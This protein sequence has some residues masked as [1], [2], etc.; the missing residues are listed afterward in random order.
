MNELTS[1]DDMERILGHGTRFLTY[2]DLARAESIEELFRKGFFVLLYEHSRNVGH[3]CCV[4]RFP[5]RIEVFDSYGIKPDDELK[6]TPR[7]FR[8]KNHMQFPH[9][10]WLLYQSGVQIEYNHHKFQ[11][12]DVATCGRHVVYRLLNR[13]MPLERY[14]YMLRDR[15]LTPDQLV[16]LYTSNI[17]L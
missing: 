2:P 15:H 8:E 6:F 4:I 13:N 3:W 17:G 14:K 16:Y 10:T 11:K 9:L 1:A 5:N 12:P 7:H